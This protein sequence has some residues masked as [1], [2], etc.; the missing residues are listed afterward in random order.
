MK[1]T[2]VLLLFLFLIPLTTSAQDYYLCEG[3]FDYDEDVDGTD[4]SLFKSDFGRNQYSYACPLDGPA[5]VPKTGQSTYFVGGDDGDL[6]RGVTWPVPRF[7]DNVDGTVSDNLTGLMWLKNANCI[8]TNYP[9][10]DTHEIPGD[11]LVTW[12]NALDFVEGINDGMY[13]DCEGNPPYNDW[14]LPNIKELQSLLD[15]GQYPALPTG[16][17]FSNLQIAYYWS[18]TT[19]S[20]LIDNAFCLHF[21]HGDTNDILKSTPHYVWSVRKGRWAVTTTTAPS[22]TTTTTSPT[23]TTSTIGP[24]CDEGTDCGEGYCCGYASVE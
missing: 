24:L 11:G 14:R 12:Q 4:A 6:E 18:S 16:H 5:P 20:N 7:T 8:N 23:T 17:P 21:R 13:P 2:V 22:S 19:C 1:Q 9:E 10:F 15:Y 3:N